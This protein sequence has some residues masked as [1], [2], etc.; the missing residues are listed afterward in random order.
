MS[1]DSGYVSNDI[2]QTQHRLIPDLLLCYDID[3]LWNVQQRS[4]GLRGAADD[5]HPVTGR[6]FDSN[7]F[8]NA[9]NLQDK[10]LRDCLLK[11]DRLR[12]FL[13]SFCGNFDRVLAR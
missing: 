11:I 4:Q 13:E 10:V 9:S 3:R 12:N 2:T 8:M 1:S 6:L 7:H 5:G